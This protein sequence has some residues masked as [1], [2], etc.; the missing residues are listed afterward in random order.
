MNIRT[1]TGSLAVATLAAT[2]SAAPAL[3]GVADSAVPSISN[4][5]ATRVAFLV[6]GV[7]KNNGL[8]TAFICTSLDT[9]AATVAVEVFPSTGGAALNNVAVGTLNGTL[10]LAAGATVTISTGSSIGL[11]ETVA[12]TGL[13]N[14]KNS[15]ARILS[16]TTKI[17]CTAILVEKNG[18]TPATVAT[19]KVI[20][21]RKQNGD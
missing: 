9:A 3:A 16:T 7:I 4:S 18:A 15:S 21:R 2:L 12:I 11:H 13:T 8:E 10:A 5:A 1:L 20:A 17:M 6:P 14:V 19:L